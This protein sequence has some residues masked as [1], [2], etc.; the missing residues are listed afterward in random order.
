MR[1]STNLIILGSLPLGALAGGLLGEAL[2]LR[3]AMVVAA[4]GTLLGVLVLVRSPIRTLR[5]LPHADG[6]SGD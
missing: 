3:P 5:E 6:G 2:G 1:A 4:C